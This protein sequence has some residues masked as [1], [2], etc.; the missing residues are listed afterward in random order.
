MKKRAKILLIIIIIIAVLMGLLYLVSL[1]TGIN[2][3][4]NAIGFLQK[5][6][7]VDQAYVESSIQEF[8]DK[9]N[10]EEKYLN[11]IADSGYKSMELIIAKQSYYLE[12]NPETNQVMQTEAKE[13]DFTMKISAK[14]FNKIIELYKEGDVKGAAMK[15]VGE[16]PRRVKIDL[17]KQCMNTEWCKQ[18]NF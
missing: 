1:L 7:V 14:K 6:E 16:I 5:T 18:G 17:F 13:T 9:A 4:G 11:F 3:T 12:Y 8:I 15:I 10:E 2:M